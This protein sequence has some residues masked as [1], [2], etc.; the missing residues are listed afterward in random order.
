L[1]NLWDLTNQI[2]TSKTEKKMNI[3]YGAINN[4]IKEA[5]IT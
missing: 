1:G 2:I 5:K 3:R 4:E